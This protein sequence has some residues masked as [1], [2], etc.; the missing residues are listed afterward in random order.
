MLADT[1]GTV[2]II[3]AEDKDR[4]VNIRRLSRL[5]QVHG[6]GGCTEVHY[7]GDLPGYGGLMQGCLIMETCSSSLLPV[8]PVCARVRLRVSDRSGRWLW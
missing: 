6:A 7:M 3:G 5:V 1:G 4:A 8:L 2:R